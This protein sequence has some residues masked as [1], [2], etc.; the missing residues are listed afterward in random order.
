MFA[1]LQLGQEAALT[2]EVMAL[3]SSYDSLGCAWELSPRT[4]WV[5]VV[6][7]ELKSPTAVL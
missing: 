7:G 4:G 3:I 1:C 2:A 5:P 6:L